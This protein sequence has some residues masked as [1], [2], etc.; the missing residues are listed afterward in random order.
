MKERILNYPATEFIN[1][2]LKLLNIGRLGFLFGFAA[3]LIYSPLPAQDSAVVQ[4]IPDAPT[5]N[6]PLRITY[7]PAIAPLEE[8]EK[9]VAVIYYT[10]ENKYSEAVRMDFPIAKEVLLLKNPDNSWE[11]L[12]EVPENANG[13]VGVFMDTL[14][15]LDNNRGE[16][17]WTPFF[18]DNQ[19]IPGAACLRAEMFASNWD[20]KSCF[21][22]DRML[23]L[24]RRLYEEEFAQHPEL[25]DRF[26]RYYLSTFDLSK[27]EDA[28]QFRKE[29]EWYAGLDGLSEWDLKAI[30]A[31]Y[32]RIN[33]IQTAEKYARLVVEKFPGG[34]WA[35]QTSSLKL[36]MSMDKVDDFGKK[37][38]IY[39][40]F[41]ETYPEFPD[42][43]TR[44]VMLGR[45][46]QLLSK[47]VP[48]FAE[49][50]TIDVWIKE[51]SE[52]DGE[53][54]YSAYKKAIWELLEIAGGNS[55]S[56]KET[57]EEGYSEHPF[58]TYSIPSEET[59]PVIAEAF[60]REAVDWWKE[61][62]HAPRRHNE[63][64]FR[65]D[66]QVQYYR[67]IRTGEMLD[68]LGLSLLAQNKYE[69]ASQV[70]KE[71]VVLS[72][73]TDAK[74]NEHYIESLLKAGHKDQLL[75]EIPEIIRSGKSTVLI[76]EIYLKLNQDSFTKLKETSATRWQKI[77]KDQLINEN[78]PDFEFKDLQGN[79]V[80][81]EMLKGKLIIIDFWA[82]WCPPCVEGLNALQEAA[83]IYETNKDVIFI[84]L[85]IEKKKDRA[86]D[87]MKRMAN[88]RHFYFDDDRITTQQFSVAA[89]PTKIFIDCQG[90]IR[91][92]TSG[93]ASF[94]RQEQVDEIVAMINFIERDGCKLDD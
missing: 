19:P 67:R 10:G 72:D 76:D 77:L 92:R 54:Q 15:N 80:T 61:N 45:R 47:L 57:K 42:E 68:L 29:L 82:S 39:K 13:V 14:G 63:R 3:I 87:F 4:F 40:Q 2:P 31:H 43:F 49:S 11:A 62:Q 46:A 74:I 17:Y 51:A 86:L 1:E 71:A 90:K 53:F 85:N 7:R 25:K 83:E 27:Q 18:S 75:Q 70:L 32:A 94:N 22:L 37:I 5:N 58:L 34:S 35:M 55:S 38:K 16:G 66:S 21:R 50:G 79:P 23:P 93:L 33:Q 59:Q 78:A 28:I 84:F 65:S 89:L 64:P 8:A 30:S 88:N 69:E 48:H 60:A 81:S 9:I 44:R 20:P 91:F 12:L 24:A 41:K 6:K 36:A 26:I 52:L 56:T 73:G